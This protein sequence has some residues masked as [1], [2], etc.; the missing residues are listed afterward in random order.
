MNFTVNINSKP[1]VS[2]IIPVY[3]A[4]HFIVECLESVISQAYE[5][6][7]IIVVD[8]GSKDKTAEIIQQKYQ[9]HVRYF[10]QSPSGG[11]AVPRNVGILHSNG[12]YLCFFDSDDI[13]A[14]NF[15]L[16][17]VD[18]LQRMPDIGMVFCDYKNFD[19]NGLY[20]KSHFQ[21]CPQ[22]WRLIDHKEEIIL[23]NACRILA[24]ENF[25]I[26]GTLM[27]RRSMLKY[28]NEF[29]QDLKSCV[30]FFFYYKLA[31]YSQVGVANYIGQMRRL[32]K[33]NITT[34]K[35]MMLNMGIR[36]RELLRENERDGQA[37]VLL[38]KYIAS[39][40]SSLSHYDASRGNYYQSFRNELRALSRNFC[41]SQ[42]LKSFKSFAR[43]ALIL[44]DVYNPR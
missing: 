7:E 34:N 18:F 9:Q 15:I 33:N 1:L 16:K 32:H 21:T 13:M 40:W 36:S 6:I 27:I 24:K 19:E 39:C 5:K 30:D 22:L 3:N 25:G 4:E 26:M 8:D 2:V 10:Y 35:Y 44:I 37:K 28:E 31:R 38:D 17:Q 20:E 41:F 29:N 11:P 12:E 23:D 14:Q 43:T 42:L